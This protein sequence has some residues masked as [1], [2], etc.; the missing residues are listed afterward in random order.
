MISRARAPARKR[1]SILGVAVFAIP[2]KV[3]LLWGSPNV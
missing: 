3:R 2:I 1:V